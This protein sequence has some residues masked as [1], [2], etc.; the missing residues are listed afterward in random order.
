MTRIHSGGHVRNPR[1]RVL[2]GE[3]VRIEQLTPAAALAVEADGDV[4][5]LTPL[6]FRVIAGALKVVC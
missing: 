4:R 3:R 5:G 2:R 6:E 1:V